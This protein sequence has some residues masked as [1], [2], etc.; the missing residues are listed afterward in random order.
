MKDILCSQMSL[1]VSAFFDTWFPEII[2]EH[3]SKD[4]HVGYDFGK[5]IC[6]F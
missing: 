2:L 5:V 4:S 3:S 6:P 1:F